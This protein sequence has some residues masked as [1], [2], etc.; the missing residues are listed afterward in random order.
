MAPALF[1]ATAALH[2]VPAESTMSST[3]MQ[4]RPSTSPTMFITSETPARS[5]R[6]SMIARS[7]SS[8]LDG[9]GAHHAAHVGR[10]DGQ[11][12]LA[13]ALHV[14]LGENRRGEAVVG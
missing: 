6:L 2:R 9:P 1:R 7:A 13:V 14:V 3:R 10:D 12:A 8:G 11:V 4:R 5:R